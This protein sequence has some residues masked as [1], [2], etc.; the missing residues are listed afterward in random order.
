[1]GTEKGRNERTTETLTFFL[2]LSIFIHL[3][4]LQ[5]NHSPPAHALPLLVLLI[6]ISEYKEFNIEIPSSNG[7]MGIQY[8]QP[9]PSVVSQQLRQTSIRKLIYFPHPRAPSS[10]LDFHPPP[11]G[12]WKTTPNVEG[13]RRRKKE[14]KKANQPHHLGEELFF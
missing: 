13:E 10:S 12:P 9:C 6:R 14:G 8:T 4:I 5:P 1:M 11:P 7:I 3:R 2:V